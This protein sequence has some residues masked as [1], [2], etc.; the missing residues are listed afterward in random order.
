ME[1][2]LKYL[3]DKDEI[4]EQ[5]FQDPYLSKIKDKNSDEEIE[6]HFFKG[7]FQTVSSGMSEH[8]GWDNG[9]SDVG[10]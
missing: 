3:I 7:N 4:I 10:I 5:I 2:E 8:S 1:I 6:M 9:N